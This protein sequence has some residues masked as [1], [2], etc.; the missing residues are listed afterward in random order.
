MKRR[1]FSL[2]RCKS[3]LMDKN[4]QLVKILYLCFIQIVKYFSF[5]LLFVQNHPYE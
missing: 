5:N 4:L 1:A 2:G 3:T